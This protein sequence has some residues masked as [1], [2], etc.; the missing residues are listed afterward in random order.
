M[1]TIA[2]AMCAASRDL[3]MLMA[4]RVL[5]CGPAI[6]LWKIHLIKALEVHI[7]P[8]DML[9][10]QIPVLETAQGSLFES[11]AICRYIASLGHN[12]LYPLPL[13]PTGKLHLHF[14]FPCKPCYKLCH[15]PSGMQPQ[16]AG[17]CSTEACCAWTDTSRAQI[18][19]WVDWCLGV[20]EPLINYILPIGLPIRPYEEAAY[21]KG[22]T[23]LNRQLETLER[24]LA[25]TGRTF[26]V[27]QALS[28][29]D[30]LVAWT[31]ITPFLVVR[32]LKALSRRAAAKSMS[33]LGAENATA[34]SQ[35]CMAF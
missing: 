33:M 28:L 22:K 11:A 31:L 15:V 17:S 9:S 21:A 16:S 32:S 24:H 25:S 2:G 5:Q 6:H 23:D 30:I 20:E 8:T 1:C 13:N 3:Q 26:L 19:A 7:R 12:N 14:T 27:G 35:H 29:A 34:H 18:D 10:L 4:L